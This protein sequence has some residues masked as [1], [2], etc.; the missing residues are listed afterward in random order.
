MIEA[1]CK[2]PS[3]IYNVQSNIQRSFVASANRGSVNEISYLWVP[4][5]MKSIQLSCV[6]QVSTFLLYHSDSPAGDQVARPR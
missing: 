6:V 5:I 3:S 1:F 2:I 4:H